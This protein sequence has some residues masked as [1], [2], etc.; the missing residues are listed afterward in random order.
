MLWTDTN[1]DHPLPQIAQNEWY[2]K[3]PDTEGK[4][5]IQWENLTKDSLLGTMLR[6]V[7]GYDPKDRTF[8]RGPDSW[9]T[10]DGI[11]NLLPVDMPNGQ[12]GA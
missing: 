8:S 12:E 4:K 1:P 9:I 11:V 2:D 7:S 6:V 3:C 5:D 10:L